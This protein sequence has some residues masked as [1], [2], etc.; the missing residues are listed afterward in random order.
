M[1]ESQIRFISQIEGNKAMEQKFSKTFVFNVP[2]VLSFDWLFEFRCD[3]TITDTQQAVVDIEETTIGSAQ[4]KMEHDGRLW[5]TWAKVWDFCQSL[6]L[7]FAS[8]TNEEDS[9]SDAFKKK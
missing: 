7:S 8:H 3:L 5:K 6:A 2:S 4:V 1:L 9:E